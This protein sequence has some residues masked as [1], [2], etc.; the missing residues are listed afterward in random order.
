MNTLSPTQAVRVQRKADAV[1]LEAD[2]QRVRT[3]AKL[4]DS[5]FEVAGVQLGWDAIIGLVPVVGDVVSAGVAMYPLH[6]ARKHQL[7]KAVQARMA[8]N[9]LID[10]A[11]GLVPLVGDVFDVGFKA[12]L[13]NLKLLEKAAGKRR[14]Q[15]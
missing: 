6:V 14:T 5:Q 3:L 11:V 8:A 15:D 1:D 4:L 7:G 13:R 10:W 2:L 12:N 9:V